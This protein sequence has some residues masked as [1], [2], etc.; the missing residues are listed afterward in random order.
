MVMV[1]L[2]NTLLAQSTTVQIGFLRP[3]NYPFVAAN[4]EAAVQIT[5]NLPPAIA[6]GLDVGR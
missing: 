1:C 4:P 2:I 3:L 5:K 6:Y